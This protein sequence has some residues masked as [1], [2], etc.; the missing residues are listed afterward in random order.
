MADPI[1]GFLETFDA[2]VQALARAT[3]ALVRKQVPDAEERLMRPWKVIAYGTRK[4][5]C[6]IAPHEQ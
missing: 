5:F 6:A 4:K 3:R 2:E 1:D